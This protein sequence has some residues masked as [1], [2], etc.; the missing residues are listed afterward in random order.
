MVNAPSTLQ[1]FHSPHSSS[2]ST[3][4]LNHDFLYDVKKY[5]QKNNN[6]TKKMKISFFNN[7]VVVVEAAAV[8]AASGE[9]IR[10]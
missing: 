7:F 9:K 2:F 3:L 10:K 4:M 8:A 5:E 6:N 1:N